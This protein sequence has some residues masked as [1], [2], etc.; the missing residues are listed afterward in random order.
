MLLFLA[1]KTA[2][3]PWMSKKTNHWI[4]KMR[5]GFKRGAFQ[6][7]IFLRLVPIFPFWV[8]NIVSSLLGVRLSTF[9]LST[10]VGIIPGSFVYVLIG[11]G[12]G[13]LLDQNKNPNL[14]II[15]TLPVFIPLIALALLSLF[16]II[17]KW[18]KGNRHE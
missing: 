5:T 2:L 15:F 3:E 6:Y 10:I 14:S 16:P 11:N 17:L 18:I 7:L 8:V 1:V 13:Q 12:L 9:F 4:Q